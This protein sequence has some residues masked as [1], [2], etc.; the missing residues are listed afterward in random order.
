MTALFVLLS[1]GSLS[2]RPSCEKLPNQ[3][4]G[5]INGLLSGFVRA[6]NVWIGHSNAKGAAGYRD[7]IYR[8]AALA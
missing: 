4:G 5:K 2:S 7:F 8:T 1:N 3:R 6:G